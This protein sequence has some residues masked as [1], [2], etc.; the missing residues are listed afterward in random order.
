M[1]ALLWDD[2][3]V[4]E[5]IELETLW[6]ELGT[7][8]RFDLYCAYPSE[9]VGRQGRADDVGHVCAL[10]SSVIG[11]PVTE[12]APAVAAAGAAAE[13]VHTRIFPAEVRSASRARNFVQQVLAGYDSQLV[14]A[15]VMTTSELA[16]NAVV[17]AGSEFVVTIAHS[18]AELRLWVGDSGPGQP[19]LRSSDWLGPAGRGLY[20]VDALATHWGVERKSQGKVVWA[21]FQLAA[22]SAA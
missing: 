9:L 2:G 14:D 21:H 1:V 7:S 10:H 19:T 6:N 16:A 22:G 20:L 13:I 4:T 3:R 11:R 15:V 5:A 8:V 12:P 17:H 18:P